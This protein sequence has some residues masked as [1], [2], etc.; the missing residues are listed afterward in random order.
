MRAAVDPHLHLA[1]V[2]GNMP[3][4][5]SEDLVAQQEQQIL[6]LVDQQTLVFQQDPQPF[7]GNRRGASA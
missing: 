1:G 4:Q 6:L 5:Q 3:A 2:D 7:P